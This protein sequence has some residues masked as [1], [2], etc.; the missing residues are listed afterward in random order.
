MLTLAV[1][2]AVEKN[3]GVGKLMAKPLAAVLVMLAIL[4][5]L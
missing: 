2:M 1:A 5:A 3:L 4:V